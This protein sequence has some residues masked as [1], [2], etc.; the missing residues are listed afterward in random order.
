V[1]F[2]EQ[3]AQPERKTQKKTFIGRKNTARHTVSKK[4]HSSCSKVNGYSRKLAAQ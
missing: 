2:S 4:I 3:S 1:F